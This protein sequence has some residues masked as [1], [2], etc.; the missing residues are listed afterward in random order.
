M[1]RRFP[2]SH[3][4]EKRGFVIKDGVSLALE[5]PCLEGRYSLPITS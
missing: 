1:V 3:D 5:N 2:S 4:K